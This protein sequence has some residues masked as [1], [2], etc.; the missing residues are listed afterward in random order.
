MSIWTD[1]MRKMALTNTGAQLGAAIN[2][3]SS[4]G[5]IIGAVNPNTYRT[6]TEMDYITENPMHIKIHRAA[7]GFIVQTAVREGDRHAV[8]IATTIEQV[9]EIITTELVTKKLEG[10]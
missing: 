2:K 4:N 9:H 7:N 8:H 3:A 10:K 6:M 1:W 5:S